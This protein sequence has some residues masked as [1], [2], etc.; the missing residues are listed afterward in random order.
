MYYT[1]VKCDDIAD[2]NPNAVDDDK[3]T[4]NYGW[5]NEAFFAKLVKESDVVARRCSA[6]V[7]RCSKNFAKIKGKHLIQSLFLNKVPVKKE[8]V[9]HMLSCK[10][11]KFI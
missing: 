11:C 9:S 8:T 10:F 1:Q 7:K 6:S 5:P 2:K 3:R 4:F